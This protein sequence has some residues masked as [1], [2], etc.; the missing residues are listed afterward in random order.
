MGKNDD[1][2]VSK[3]LFRP[4]FFPVS[5][6]FFLFF[7]RGVSPYREPLLAPFQCFLFFF[8]FFFPVNLPSPPLGVSEKPD[9]NRLYRAPPYCQRVRREA[10]KKDQKEKKRDEVRGLEPETD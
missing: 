9:W 7:L 8:T 2:N 10:K 3:P 5:F 1:T 4:A 6:S